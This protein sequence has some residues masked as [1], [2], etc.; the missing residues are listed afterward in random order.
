MELLRIEGSRAALLGL[1][2]V[3]DI[4]VVGPSAVDRGD[5]SWLVSVY[6]PEEAVEDLSARGLTVHR[7]KPAAQ[8]REEWEAAAST[9][10]AA[11]G[12]LDSAAVA[13]RLSGPRRRA[14]GRVRERGASAAHA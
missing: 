2:D 1:R 11:T 14:S 13:Q 9:L 5:G 3:A 7:L 8:L 10:E 4:H 6:A 12:W